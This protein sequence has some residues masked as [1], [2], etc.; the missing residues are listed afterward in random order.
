MV[1]ISVYKSTS[2]T[3]KKML[4]GPSLKIYCVKELPLANREVRR[5]LKD[6]ISVWEQHCNTDSFLKFYD[7]FWNQPEGCVSIVQDCAPKSSLQ[8]LISQVGALPERTLQNL[9]KQILKALNHMHTD[10]LAHSN[11]TCSQVLFD[12]RGK[13]RLSLGFGHILR[14]KAETQ[15]TLSHHY[16]L[17]QLLCDGLNN[18]A[19]KQ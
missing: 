5:I 2:G 12:R 1:T 16:T 6:W 3:I 4:H 13:V 14:A 17:C 7:A 15:S 19:N 9:A 18:F 8:D 11:V 10:N